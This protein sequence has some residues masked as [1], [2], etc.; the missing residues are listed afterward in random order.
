MTAEERAIELYDLLINALRAEPE[1][2]R[3]DVCDRLAANPYFCWYC[4]ADR[5]AK[6]GCPH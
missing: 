4:G 3:Q 6:C 2:I 5:K 1:D